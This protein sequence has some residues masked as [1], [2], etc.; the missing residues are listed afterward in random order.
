VSSLTDS[1]VCGATWSDLRGN[2]RQGAGRKLH[3]KSFAAHAGIDALPGNTNIL[4]NPNGAVRRVAGRVCRYRDAE[5]AVRW[6]AAGFLQTE[7]SMRRLQGHRD[8]WV[9][10][11]ALGRKSIQTGNNN[12]RAA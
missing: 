10:S 4:E 7:K 9:L 5:M 12:V 1:L 8:L 11:T 3:G 2:D 6:T